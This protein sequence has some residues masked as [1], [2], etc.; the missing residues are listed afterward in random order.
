[1]SRPCLAL[2]LVLAC[3]SP[4]LAQTSSTSPSLLENLSL[5]VGPEGSKQPQDLGINANMGIRF[6]ANWAFPLLD[7]M[8]LGAQIGA[9]VNV[10]DSAVHV[11]D[12][13]E[14]TSRR[15]QTFV[16]AGVFQRPTPRINWGLAYD[17]SVVRYYDD[18]VFG[19]VRGQAGYNVTRDNEVG[20]WFT[21]AVRGDEGAFASTPVHLDPI[22]QINGYWRRIWPTAAQ[23]SLWI[24]MA[25]AHHNVVWVFPDNSRDRHVLVYGADLAM[26]LSDRFAVTGAAN[27]VTPTSTGTVDA[28]LGLS[29]YPGRS[30]QRLATN[31][32][33]PVNGV[34]NNT[35]MPINLSR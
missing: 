22:S 5:F 18:F 30:A 9:A 1:M 4:S 11:V 29:F 2:A 33:T 20:V 34:A 16:T 14:G 7:A 23:T 31:R 17:I 21:K 13:I 8:N 12:Q 10:S 3:S 27:L 35:S 25:S 32:F 28:F 26:P 24:G 19:Q 6:A 15:T